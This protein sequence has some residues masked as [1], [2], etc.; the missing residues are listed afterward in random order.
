MMLLALLLAAATPAAPS[1]APPSPTVADAPV[2]ADAL[3]LVRVLNPEGLM[4]EMVVR[5]FTDSMR[6]AIK[7]SDD[8]RALEKEY[9][10]ISEAL[11]EAMA[12]AMQADFVA[13]LPAVRF[14]Y[15]RFYADRFSPDETAQLMHFYSSGAGQR[16]VR[17]KFSKLDATPMV[18]EFVENPDT[19]VSK[20]HIRDLNRAATMSMIGD[21][22]DED[23]AALM[24]FAKQPVFVKLAQARGDIEQLEADIA[25]EADPELDKALEAATNAVFLKFTGEP[26][27]GK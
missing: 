12:G 22:S 13:D 20:D 8:Y 5:N 10:G 18:G 25:N 9:P 6:L 19:A 1:A 2:R 24:Q 16:L 26:P 4:A 3:E 15:A 21:M 11:I 17:A 7:A 14:R 27:P 23:R